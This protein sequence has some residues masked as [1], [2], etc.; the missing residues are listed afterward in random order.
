MKKLAI[1]LVLVAGLAVPSAEAGI[2]TGSEVTLTGSLGTLGGGA[3][4]AVSPDSDSFLTFCLE[5]NEYIS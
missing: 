2:I 4:T 3:F 5:R 1:I